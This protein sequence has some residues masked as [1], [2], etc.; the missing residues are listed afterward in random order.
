MV[1]HLSCYPISHTIEMGLRYAIYELSYCIRSALWSSKVSCLQEISLFPT[2]IQS[3][4]DMQPIW[5]VGLVLVSHTDPNTH[6]H[7]HTYMQSI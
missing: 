2:Q 1:F 6:T 5:I 4:L 7:T 3:H